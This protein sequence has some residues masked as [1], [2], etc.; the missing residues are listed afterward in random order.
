MVRQPQQRERA[1][2]QSFGS[3]V[4]L[5]QPCW[6]WLRFPEGG[7]WREEASLDLGWLGPLGN[8]LLELGSCTHLCRQPSGNAQ[9]SPDGRT[10]SERLHL[11]PALAEDVASEEG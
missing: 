9:G 3:A 6:W 8:A 1:L 2:K 4:A 7:A 5:L 10:C 11:G